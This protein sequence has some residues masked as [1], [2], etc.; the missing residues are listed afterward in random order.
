MVPM[1][2]YQVSFSKGKQLYLLEKNISLFYDDKLL[3]IEILI[4]VDVIH[5]RQSWP[6]IIHGLYLRVEMG[7]KPV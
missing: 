4:K 5:F 1:V 7:R 6:T 3:F 2:Y